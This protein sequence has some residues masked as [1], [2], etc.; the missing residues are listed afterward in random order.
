MFVNNSKKDIERLVGQILLYHPNLTHQKAHDFSRKIHNK[1]V[2]RCFKTEHYPATFENAYS[3]V[4][5]LDNHGA[6]NYSKHV[7]SSNE[8]DID[9]SGIYWI[10]CEIECES[11]SFN[12]ESS[13]YK[14]FVH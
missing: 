10:P 5:T 8:A 13:R 7:E 3:Y 12:P 4:V 9:A 14:H 2:Q 1:F 6:L 11:V